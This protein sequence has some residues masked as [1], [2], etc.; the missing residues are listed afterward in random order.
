MMNI[1]SLT[2]NALLAT[3][4]L[5]LFAIGCG[6]G[7]STPEG[8]ISAAPTETGSEDMAIINPQDMVM[9]IDDLSITIEKKEVYLFEFALSE[10]EMSEWVLDGWNLSEENLQNVNYSSMEHPM[11]ISLLDMHRNVWY[12]E[13]FAGCSTEKHEHVIE[14]KHST[15]P[16]YVVFTV[17]EDQAVLHLN[18]IMGK[19]YY[20]FSMTF[21]CWSAEY[22]APMEVPVLIAP[23]I[24]NS[25][26]LGS[27]DLLIGE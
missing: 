17:G 8:D 16:S 3:G 23:E 20:H 24:G 10:N 22:V 5:S 18:S 15:T 7:G 1:T 9:R 25:L 26:S 19:K 27:D 11:N 21:T 2:R 12:S 13:D 4:I 6:G 14:F